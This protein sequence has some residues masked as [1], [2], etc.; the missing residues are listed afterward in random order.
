VPTLILLNALRKPVYPTDVG[1][2]PNKL[3]TPISLFLSE[4][5]GFAFKLT[6]QE[7]LKPL[8]GFAEV[9]L[10]INLINTRIVEDVQNKIGDGVV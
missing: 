1:R 6:W 10:R 3:V 4:L 9:E 2:N 5:V 8:R 7:A